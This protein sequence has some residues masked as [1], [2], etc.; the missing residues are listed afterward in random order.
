MVVGPNSEVENAMVGANLETEN[1]MVGANSE[2]E[3]AIVGVNTEVTTDCGVVKEDTRR[4]GLLQRSLS[5]PTLSRNT[6]T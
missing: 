6:Q 1:A 2:V 4:M 3:T 5:P